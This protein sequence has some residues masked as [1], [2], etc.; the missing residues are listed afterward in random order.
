ML[1]FTQSCFRF[2]IKSLEREGKNL[3]LQL[4]IWTFC[5][6]KDEKESK[7]QGTNFESEKRIFNGVKYF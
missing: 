7:R 5:L 2:K 1:C 3:I 4:K 6:S